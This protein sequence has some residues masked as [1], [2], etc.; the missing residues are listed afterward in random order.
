MKECELQW[1]DTCFNV[2]SFQG[3]SAI[4]NLNFLFTF[5]FVQAM[6]MIILLFLLYEPGVLDF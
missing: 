5:F 6:R 1:E 3:K 4:V 2:D